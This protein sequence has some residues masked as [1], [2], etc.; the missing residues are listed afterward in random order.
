MLVFSHLFFPSALQD[1]QLV[2]KAHVN[3]VV[4]VALHK[5]YIVVVVDSDFCE[6]FFEIASNLA[7]VGSWQFVYP[8]L[9][10]K[11]HAKHFPV[12]FVDLGLGEHILAD[13]G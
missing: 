2:L 9:V 8:Q 5:F 10:V 4:V 12:D 7:L 3:L 6:R 1:S 13:L 11:V